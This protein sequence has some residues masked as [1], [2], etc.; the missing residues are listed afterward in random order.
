MFIFLNDAGK[1][2]LSKDDNMQYRLPTN[3]FTNLISVSFIDFLENGIIDFLVCTSGGVYAFYNNYLQQNLFFI[4]GYGASG[5]SSTTGA[6]IVGA[7]FYWV[8]SVGENYRTTYQPQMFQ[9]AYG[10]LQTPFAYCGLGRA[11]NYV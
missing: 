7:S 3:S 11:N 2:F 4:K 9:T 1:G 10:A 8:N 6:L 5:S